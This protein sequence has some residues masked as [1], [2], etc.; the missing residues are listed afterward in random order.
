MG[1]LCVVPLQGITDPL[2]LKYPPKQYVIHEDAEAVKYPSLL[3]HKLIG[4]R[5]DWMQHAQLLEA[6]SKQRM[7]TADGSQA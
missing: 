1:C 4:E 5:A 2:Y 7:L 3:R 6:G